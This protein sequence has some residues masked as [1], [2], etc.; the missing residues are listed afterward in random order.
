MLSIWFSSLCCSYILFFNNLLFFMIEIT[1]M[2]YH[3]HCLSF[4]YMSN[5]DIEFV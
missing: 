5:V 2:I 4:Y 1:L 3:L